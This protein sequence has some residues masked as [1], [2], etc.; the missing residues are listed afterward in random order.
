MI[1]LHSHTSASDGQHPP[2]EHVGLAAR[3]GIRVLAITDHDTVEGLEEALAACTPLG[4]RLV[5]GIEVSISHNRREL[6]IL[7]HFID[8][9]EP[10][11]AAHARTLA[12]EREAR[13]VEMLRRLSTVGITLTLDQVRAI[14]VDAPL[15]RPHLARALVEHRVCS[16]LKD[17]FD[18]F[19]GDGK[20]AHVTKGEVTGEA[21]IA[22][23]HRAGGTATLAHPGA[24]RVHRLELS[25]LRAA[26]L[27]G[28]EVDHVDHPPSQRE[29]F[30]AWA[31]ALDLATTAGSDF[32]GAKVTPDRRFGSVTM[33]EAE[34]ALLEA[35]RPAHAGSAST[36]RAPGP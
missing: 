5:P 33:T 36:V 23:I 34:L 11:L 21:A 13:M 20:I 35:R 3:A 2:S 24:S 30:R 17:A 26:G 14:A 22:L 18:R 29:T 31:H 16:S 7:G 9:R 19:L 27:D 10:H 28:L 1:D 8:P 4:L 15:A 12:L 32:H 25:E 6:H